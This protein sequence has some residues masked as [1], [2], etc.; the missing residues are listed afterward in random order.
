VNNAGNRTNVNNK[1]FFIFE[2]LLQT[3]GRK[4]EK[5]QQQ[6]I[7]MHL[8]SD[9]KYKRFPHKNLTEN[10]DVLHSSPNLRSK[11]LMAM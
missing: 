11:T 2:V 7:L 9:R 6:Q 5:K 8:I 1:L 10:K 4:N 3:Q